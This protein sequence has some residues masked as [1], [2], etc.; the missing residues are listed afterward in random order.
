MH[1]FVCNPCFTP[2]PHRDPHS[3]ASNELCGIDRT[4]VEQSGGSSHDGGSRSHREEAIIALCKALK[5]ASA[6]SSLTSLDVG[7]RI[8]FEN[9]GILAR[10]I[11]GIADHL[12]TVV[13]EHATM[14]NFCGIP[15]DSLR[16][17]SIT[18]LDLGDKGVGLP[19]AI[20]LSKLL[21][22]AAALTS[23]KCA[24]AARNRAHFCVS[25]P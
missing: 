16:E 21:P 18:E 14:T 20:V 3:L 11:T 5:G 9:T 15:F 25:A 23:L 13:L 22:S 6:F 4:R 24:Y 2:A 10:S 1:C 12:A 17:N 19:G 8:D 7:S